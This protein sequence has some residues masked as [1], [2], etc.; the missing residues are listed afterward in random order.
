MEVDPD[1]DLLLHF[2]PSFRPPHECGDERCHDLF[3][4]FMY[5]VVLPASVAFLL[6]LVILFTLAVCCCVERQVG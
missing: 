3:P 2:D 6:V 5:I 1:V 4:E